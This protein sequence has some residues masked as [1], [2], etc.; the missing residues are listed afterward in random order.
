MATVLHAEAVGAAI[1]KRV[2]RGAAV[3][4]MLDGGLAIAL[5]RVEVCR[6]K[7]FIIHHLLSCAISIS[8]T[9][10]LSP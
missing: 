8:I 9:I 6:N 1:A 7:T 4:F 10:P 3:N 5:K 2:T